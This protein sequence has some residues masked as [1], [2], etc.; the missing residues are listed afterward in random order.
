MY[1]TSK[2]Q[3]IPSL[4]HGMHQKIGCKHCIHFRIHREIWT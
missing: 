4:L 1:T 2:K 3:G